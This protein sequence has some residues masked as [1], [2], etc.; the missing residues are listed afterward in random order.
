VPRPE[1]KLITFEI[2]GREVSAPEGML[3]VDA[4]K[5]G[6]VEIPY[7]CYEPRLGQPVGAC[8]MCLVEIEGMPKLQT[9]CST[10]VKDGMVVTTTSDRV[11][12]A[13]NAIVEFLLV[14]HPLDCPVCDK[15]GECPLQ[16]ISFGWGAGRSRVIEP[17]RHFKKP[18]ELSPLVAI[19]RERC[20]LCYR[21]VRFSQEIAEDH[22]LVFLERGDHTYVGTHHGHPYVAPF[23]GNIV[24]LCPVGALTSTAYR[25]R[26][27]P[28]DIENAG[29]VCTLCPAQCNV[30]FSVRDDMKVLRV[31]DSRHN[32]HVDDGWTCDKGRYGYQIVN[33]G[34]RITRPIVRE[35]GALLERS[36]EYA[37]DRVTKALKQAGSK[38]ALIAGGETT[39]EEAFLA[40]KLLREALGSNDLDSRVGPVDAEQARV[41]AKPELTA[42]VPDVEWA[43]AVL[44]LETELV[45]EMP[46]L[47][48][49]VRKGRRRN[50]VQV[51]VA[52]SHPSALDRDA[53]ATV[54][55]APGSG[56]ALLTA[57]AAALGSNRVPA[58]SADGPVPD[59]T[60]A[61]AEPPAEPAEQPHGDPVGAMGD[62]AT[63]ADPG[64][65]APVAGPGGRP[66]AMA[67]G[68]PGEQSAEGE[69]P[70][71]G[72]D[73][74]GSDEGYAGGE[75]ASES[76]ADSDRG[77]TDA[78]GAERGVGKDDRGGSV[79]ASKGGKRAAKPADSGAR[80]KSLTDR[81]QSPKSVPA[82]TDDP[83]S[84]LADRAGSDPDAIRSLAR[85]LRGAGS[86]VI[87]WGE[88]L[89]HG[90][91][92]K[93]AVDAL[94]AV[95]QALDVAG[96]EGSGLLEVPA[97]PNGRGLREVGLLP[98]AGPG[99]ADADGRGTAD[100]AEALVGGE[101]AAL[102]LLHADPLATHPNRARWEAALDR[103]T[104][105]VAFAEFVDGGVTEHADVI[106]P[107]ESYA[108]REGT[109]VH[110]DGR[111][112]R[113]RQTVGHPGE[114]RPVWWALE[115]ILERLGHGTGARTAPMVSEQIFNAVPFYDGL[116]LDE[117]G[118]RGVRW[119]ERDAA[120]KLPAAELPSGQLADPP[121]AADANGVLRLGTR[122]SLWTGYVAR[123]APVL[124]FLKPEQ[125]VELSPADAERLGL[126]SGASVH[127]GVNG[128]RIG[129]KALV[130]AGVPEGTAL[131]IEGTDDQ[132][133]GLLVN[134]EPQTVEVTPE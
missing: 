70:A 117:I 52:S 44:V 39:N 18:L 32:E 133:A 116:T 127:V 86:V 41:L 77:D 65:P 118:G 87:V 134:G 30:E 40:Q 95:A 78:A 115:Q 93:Q 37:L 59:G 48:L 123:H 129:A 119:Q 24:S 69:Q 22:Q 53:A 105:V 26:A 2:D 7:F 12:H 99:F 10:P 36:W 97:G 74:S 125:T 25:F 23:S 5:N 43:D 109:V 79:S 128:T 45:D 112:Q 29:T 55:F 103:A 96:T 60:G 63:E 38:T 31:Y 21:C 14:N 50:G 62:V 16:D 82:G 108:E 17:K 92:G 1:P 89:S 57:L 9:S 80:S 102:V 113:L 131:L 68:P 94:L 104:F 83:I 51:T 15:G 49:R 11:K 42:S 20:I 19:D 90:P 35:G 72:V 13:Q 46:I 98:N 111:L 64:A 76:G 100:I 130:R 120:S 33:S 8:R 91:R 73:T 61:D 84:V 106:L 3:L 34:D 75:S 47:E 56:E 88:R 54:R 67:G 66:G 107:A 71:A 81:G 101:S 114:V 6:D 132:P 126:G 110:P 124:E 122:P 85:T 28:W 58:V 121:A 4:A 27:R